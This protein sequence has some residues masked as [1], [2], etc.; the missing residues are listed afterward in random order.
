MPLTV[1]QLALRISVGAGKAVAC[2]R[3]VTLTMTRTRTIHL[4][5]DLASG[6]MESGNV[7][8]FRHDVGGL[9]VAYALYLSKSQF[10][11]L[12]L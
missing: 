1:A 5:H 9:V 2:L 11:H 6:R 12:S 4:D 10:R 8:D 7:S 3:L